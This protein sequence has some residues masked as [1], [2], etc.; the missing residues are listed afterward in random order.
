MSTSSESR[1][2]AEHLCER[3]QPGDVAVVVGAQDVDQ[4]IEASRVLP[5]NV[6]GVRRVVARCSVRTDENAILVVAVCARTRPDRPFRLVRVEERD[7][8]GD[9]AFDVAL[10]H[11]RVEM[12]AEALEGRLDPLQHRRDGVA[13]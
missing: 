6:G 2:L 4:A 9:L 7:R 12:D 3:L 8:L 13:G 5:A 11:P 1:V 10:E